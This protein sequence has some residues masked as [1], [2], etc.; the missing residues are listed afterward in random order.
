MKGKTVNTIIKLRVNQKMKTFDDLMIE[1]LDDTLR[2]VLGKNIS[3]LIHTYKKKR[4]ALKISKIDNNID[5]VIDYLEK[6]IGKESTQVIQ[7][8]SI[9]RLC[10]KLKREYEEV[11]SHF[12]FLDE[13]YEMKFNLLTPIKSEKQTEHN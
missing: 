8:I 7:S 3:N 10:F 12:S 4:T 2:L 5:D 9:K 13:L 1:E 6:L 11:E